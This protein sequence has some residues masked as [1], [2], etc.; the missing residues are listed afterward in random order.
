MQACLLEGGKQSFNDFLADRLDSLNFL[1]K[2]SEGDQNLFETMSSLEELF[3]AT[4]D[5]DFDPEMET[6]NPEGQAVAPKKRP[7]APVDDESGP[8]NAS[9]A[10]KSKTAVVDTSKPEEATAH[11][12]LNTS[13]EELSEFHQALVLLGGDTIDQSTSSHLDVSKNISEASDIS[14]LINT[15]IEE[16]EIET[17]ADQGKDDGSSNTAAGATKEPDTNAGTSTSAPLRMMTAESMVTEEER[18]KMQ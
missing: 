13:G 5:L 7:L 9:T 1:R 17:V 3:G 11:G 10:K 18:L 6:A 12:G 2:G 4:H 14:P 16:G 8:S 15:S